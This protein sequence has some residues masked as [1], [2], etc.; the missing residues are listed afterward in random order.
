MKKVAKL[1]S[2]VVLAFYIHMRIAWV[3]QLLHILTNIG[4]NQVFFIIGY[5]SMYA[6]RSHH[7]EFTLNYPDD[8]QCWASFMSF[9]MKCQF[10]IFFIFI[11]LFISLLF[12]CRSYLYILDTCD[13]WIYVLWLF[14]SC[15]QL[16]FSFL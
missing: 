1:F 6:V 14:S 15:L 3:F 7:R 13:S 11:G 9:F 10:N 2:R 5:F 8:W 4:Q 12:S 16:A